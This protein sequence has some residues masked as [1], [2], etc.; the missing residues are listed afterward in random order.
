[1]PAKC[2]YSAAAFRFRNCALRERSRSSRPAA[3]L[4]QKSHYWP[5]Q[6]LTVATGCNH[7]EALTRQDSFHLASGPHLTADVHE[8]MHHEAMGQPPTI[9]SIVSCNG[10]GILGHPI[11][12][13]HCQM[14]GTQSFEPRAQA[15]DRGTAGHQPGNDRQ[16]QM[17]L[18]NCCT[19]HFDVPPT[20][21]LCAVFRLIERGI[22]CR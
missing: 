5:A 21:A 2:E 8:R 4:P 1:V 15:C 9:Q 10:S 16:V 12:A 6:K 13:T 18:R 20:D 22:E 17:A 3:E 7:Q 19:I 14:R 11:R